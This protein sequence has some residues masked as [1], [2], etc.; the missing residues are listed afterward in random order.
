MTDAERIKKL[1]ENVD[2]LNGFI[3]ALE[4]Q[5]EKAWH[6]IARIGSGDLPYGECIHICRDFFKEDNAE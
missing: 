2:Y 3:N 4:A 1:E 5:R 6:L